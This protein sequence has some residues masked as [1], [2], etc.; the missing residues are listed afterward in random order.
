[1]EA[2]QIALTYVGVKLLD[3]LIVTGMDVTSL[4]ES[5]VL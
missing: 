1:M 3:H 4:A 2:L 5:G